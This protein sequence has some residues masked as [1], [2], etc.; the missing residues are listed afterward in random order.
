MALEEF[1]G[2]I[3]LDGGFLPAYFNRAICLHLMNLPNE[4]RNAWTKYLELDPNSS[5][6]QEAQTRLDGLRSDVEGDPPAEVLESR[7]VEYVKSN[8]DDGALKIAS[9]NRELIKEKYLPQRLAFSIVDSSDAETRADG[10]SALNRLASIERER[11]NDHFATDIYRLYSNRSE[12]QIA[13]LKHAQDLVREGYQLCL[14][15]KFNDAVATFKQASNL[16]VAAD[17]VVEAQTIANYFTGYCLENIGKID[18]ADKIFKSVKEFSEQRGYRWLAVMSAYWWLGSQEYRGLKSFTETRDAYAIVL[19]DAQAMGDGYMSQKLLLSIILEDDRVGDDEATLGHILQLLEISNEPGLSVRQKYRNLDKIIQISSQDGMHALSN[20][21]LN[22]SISV[23]NQI[24]DPAFAFG[25]AINAGIVHTSSHRFPEAAQWL[26]KA[27]EITSTLADQHL[28]DG[29]LSRTYLER[30][31][32]EHE[33]NQDDKALSDYDRALALS[34]PTAANSFVFDIRKARINSLIATGS[35]DA[36]SDEIPQTI[37][38]AEE[39]RSR[40]QDERE[41][42]NFFETEQSLYDAA[43]ENQLR[44]KDSRGAYNY[45]EMSSSRSLLDWIQGDSHLSLDGD[46]KKLLLNTSSSSLTL[47]EIQ[48]RIPAN[49]QIVE[50]RCLPD[51]LVIWI[52]SRNEFSSVAVPVS[53]NDLAAIVKKYLYLIKARSPTNRTV[54]DEIARDLYQVL[55]SPIQDSLDRKKDLSVVPNRSL[56]YLPFASLLSP[57]GER[58]IEEFPVV[59]APS[60]SVFISCSDRASDKRTD[61]EENI[62]AIGNPSIDKQRFPELADISDSANEARTVANTYPTSRLMTGTSVTKVDFLAASKTSD[63]IHFAGHY[64]VDPQSPQLSKLLLADESGDSA[65]LTNADLAHEKFPRTRLIVLSG[66]QTALE[67][68]LQG[69]GAIGLARTFLGTG[70][71]VVVAS[72]WP[73]DSAATTDLMI[74]FHKFRRAGLP[75]SE[76][77]RQAQISLL[78]Q[79]D[80]N[81]SDPYYWSGFAVFGGAASF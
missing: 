55:I 13:T 73:V 22:E 5:W 75:S 20:A 68:T 19:R 39:Y 77:L 7:F 63:V 46:S 78:R 50:Y 66:C 28:R 74:S 35:T 16:F 71:P 3:S 51:A 21:V 67:G 72:Q 37:R 8:N 38:L 23:S 11:I 36:L 30:G 24:N 57:T 33:F 80:N 42:S 9:Q 43:V 56:F 64:V 65:F 18:E 70:I 58:L 27:E 44:L 59:Y 25:A 29:Y 47:D 40:I 81:N 48:R 32:L 54:R 31:R 15:D 79:T 49:S 76:A 45:A 2:S 6:A 26:A 10:L 14:S 61:G 60:A 53:S 1:D 17:D 12:K 69:E 62:L 4:E 34:G 52:V 41:R